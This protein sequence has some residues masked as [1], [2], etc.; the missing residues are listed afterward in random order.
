MIWFTSDHHFGH[1]NIINFCN[2][3]YSDVI[4]MEKDLVTRFN[5][6][7]QPG[8]VVYF[9]GDIVWDK[10][11]MDVLPAL[12]GVHRFVLG[13]HDLRFFTE[14]SPNQCPPGVRKYEIWEVNAEGQPIVLCHFPLR[15]WNGSYHGVWH[16]HGHCHGRAFEPPHCLDVSVDAWEFYPVSL[17]Q[18]REEMDPAG[19]RLVADIHA[20]V[21]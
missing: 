21:E 8:D 5:S 3:P 18:I 4:Q 17:T 19:A 20:S 10:K 11:S 16:L 14:K 2:R 13:G 9:I 15:E 12:H 7:V 6:V 1:S